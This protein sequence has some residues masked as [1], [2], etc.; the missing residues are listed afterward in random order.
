MKAGACALPPPP[1]THT[2]LSSLLS[3]FLQHQYHTPPSLPLLLPSSSSSISPSLLY[4]LSLCRSVFLPGCCCCCCFARCGATLRPHRGVKR[5]KPRTERGASLSQSG[6]LAR[7][8]KKGFERAVTARI[9]KPPQKQKKQHK[10]ETRHTA[11]FLPPSLCPLVGGTEEEVENE[12]E[13]KQGAK[14]CWGISERKTTND[15]VLETSPPPL[16]DQGRSPFSSQL[17]AATP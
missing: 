4:S 9:K 17:G 13:D 14:S 10:A 2:S 15:A 3:L 7:F 8:K 5:R 16:P 12:K 11:L 1:N 6:G